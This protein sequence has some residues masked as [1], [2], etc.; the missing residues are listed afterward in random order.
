MDVFSYQLGKKSS[1]GGGGGV[2]IY[3]YFEQYPTIGSDKTWYENIKRLPRMEIVAQKS[4]TNIFNSFKGEYIDVSGIDTS[5]ATSLNGCFYYCSN[6]KEIDLSGWDIGKV[7]NISNLF[8]YCTS[9]EK[10]D[11]R[12][13]FMANISLKNNVF[14]VQGSS[15]I[16]ADC[17]V[18]VRDSTQKNWVQTDYPWL[19]NVKTPDEL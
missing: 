16:P 18:I 19:T 6:L 10:I 3:D 11:L 15:G 4:F 7:T 2:D 9:I 17:L 1:G 12:T 5:N 13:W 8:G 14:G